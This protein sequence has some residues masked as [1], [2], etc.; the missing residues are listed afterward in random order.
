MADPENANAVIFLVE[1]ARRP[2]KSTRINVM[3]PEDLINAIDKVTTN[4]SRFLAEAARLKL[5]QAA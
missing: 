1:T 2:A 4:R 5:Q 3:L